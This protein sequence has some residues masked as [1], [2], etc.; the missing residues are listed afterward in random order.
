MSKRKTKCNSTWKDTFSWINPVKG[1]ECSANCSIC[2]KK[3]SI[4]NGGVSDI[5]QHSKTA[6][7]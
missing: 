1:N 6:L 7:Q 4:H 3:F 5:K 2:N